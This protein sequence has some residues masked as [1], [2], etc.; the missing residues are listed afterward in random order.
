MNINPTILDMNFGRVRSTGG[1][2]YGSKFEQG[3]RSA[4]RLFSS[5]IAYS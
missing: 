3:I 1:V 2:Y 5:Y 4:K